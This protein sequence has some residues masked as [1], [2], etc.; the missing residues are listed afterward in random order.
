M[1]LFTIGE[2][3]RQ[4]EIEYQETPVL[5]LVEMNG[6]V[7]YDL[8]IAKAIG[9]HRLQQVGKD[10]YIGERPP[11]DLKQYY[12]TPRRDMLLSVTWM[13]DSEACLEILSIEVL[14]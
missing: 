8:V 11:Y 13:G 12:E 14:G 5:P 3:M 1:D 6:N 9:A 4:W 10:E 7:Y 2:D